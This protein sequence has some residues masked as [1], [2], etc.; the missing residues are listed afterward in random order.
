MDTLKDQARAIRDRAEMAQL[1]ASK[2]D[3]F[4]ANPVAQEARIVWEESILAAWKGSSAADGEFREQLY[5]AYQAGE[6]FWGYLQGVSSA[7]N[8]TAKTAAEILGLEN[9]DSP[10]RD[11]RSA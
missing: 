5:H 8:A 3:G 6:K 7:G 11:E 9:S 10:D 4:L 1:K 2:A